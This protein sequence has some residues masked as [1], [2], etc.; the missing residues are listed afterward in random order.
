MIERSL[1]L[2]KPDAVGRWLSGEIISRFEKVGLKIVGMKMMQPD[3][4]FY[5]YHYETISEMVS[6]RGEKAFETTLSYMNTGPVI[7]MVL[8]GVEAIALIRKMIGATNSKDALPGTIRGD[9]SH[10]SFDFA[11]SIEQGL[12]NIIH[13]SGNAEEAAKEITHWFQA[14]ELHDYQRADSGFIY[15]QK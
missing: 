2:L 10:M 7:A 4:D 9:F 6:R 11:D 8:E 13:A 3:R 5:Y 12:P 15:G 1:I 14:T